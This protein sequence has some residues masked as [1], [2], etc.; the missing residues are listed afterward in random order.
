LPSAPG[1]RQR[2][3]PGQGALALRKPARSAGASKRATKES[4]PA[5][6]FWKPRWSLDRGPRDRATGVAPV[7]RLWKSRMRLTTLRPEIEPARGAGPGDHP[8]EPRS[9][10]SFRPDCQ[11]ASRPVPGIPMAAGR[12]I[13]GEK[14]KTPHTDE[15][16]VS[17]T[18]GGGL[19]HAVTPARGLRISVSRREMPI[20]T[21]CLPWHGANKRLRPSQGSLASFRFAGCDSEHVNPLNRDSS[22]RLPDFGMDVRNTPG[23]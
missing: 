19:G 17:G 22:K 1:D 11:S 20:A 2:S 8:P 16:G 5:A 10:S 14:Q 3:E 13:C 12:T 4:H 7:P 23:W 15:C 9:S 6:R 21:F 18:P